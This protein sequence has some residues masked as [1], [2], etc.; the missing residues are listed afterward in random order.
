MA[1]ASDY[2]EN[3]TLDFWL[4]ANSQ[5]SSAPSTVYVSLHTGSPAD[6]DSGANEVSGGAYA[7]QSATFGTISN[8]SVSTSATITYPVA[9]AN[10]GTVSHIGI[11]DAS[12]SG[13]L[14]FHGAVTT[15][16][17]IETGDQFQISS[18]NLTVTMA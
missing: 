9:T 4:K 13:N 6:D 7:R 3:R 2:V 14:L 10:Y 16:K 17:T 11:Y 12:T 5:T 8:G 1:A 18:G 15:S